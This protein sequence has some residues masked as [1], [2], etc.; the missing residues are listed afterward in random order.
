[1][2]IDLAQIVKD[3]GMMNNSQKQYTLLK[4][5]VAIA[6]NA[7]KEGSAEAT[8][9]A[10]D[11][12]YDQTE[13]CKDSILYIQAKLRETRKW[14]EFFGSDDD[15]P[16][17]DL[18]E[19]HKF[20]RDM[21]SLHNIDQLLGDEIGETYKQI[22]LLH[23]LEDAVFTYSSDKDFLD[24]LSGYQTRGLFNRHFTVMYRGIDTIEASI[25]KIKERIESG[26]KKCQ[27]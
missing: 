5:V 17:F 14:Y 11:A 1:M 22:R 25:Q 2:D 12:F 7:K 15:D 21:L 20:E 8:L 19:Q 18:P 3:S 16:G 4:H 26:M 10:L 24:T 27:H 6:S 13:K 23:Q 9:K